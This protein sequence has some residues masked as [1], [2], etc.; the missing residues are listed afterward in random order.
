M[1]VTDWG[2]T[3]KIER[4][5]MDG[6]NRKVIY[7]KPDKAWGRS[8]TIDYKTSIIYWGDTVE[9][10]IGSMTIDGTNVQYYKLD[11]PVSP[12]YISVSNSMV[13]WSDGA[14]IS[15]FEKRNFSNI[16]HVKELNGSPISPN[17][18]RVFESYRKP[19]V[20]TPCARNNGG[21]SHLCLLRFD[22]YSCACPTGVAL[23]ED[24][25]TCKDGK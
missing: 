7:N 2:S 5:N 21:C 3:K 14:S 23:K 13:F 12:N 8:I 22:G 6:S 15:A 25:R 1:F 9:N 20:D 10:M 11:P 18:L 24:N 4:F 16:V 17:D 19:E